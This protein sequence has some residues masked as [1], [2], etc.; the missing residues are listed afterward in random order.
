MED[1]F[2]LIREGNVFKVRSWLDS[3]ENDFNQT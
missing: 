2:H 3:T 1:I